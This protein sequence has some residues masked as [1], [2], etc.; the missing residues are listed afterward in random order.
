MSFDIHAVRARFPALQK[1]VT[2]PDGSR[3]PPILLNCGATTPPMREV[4]ETVNAMAAHYG[5]LGRGGGPQQA[6]AEALRRDFCRRI[7]RFVGAPAD[8]AVIFGQ[9]TTHVLNPII[10]GL[11]LQSGDVAI[12]TDLGHNSTGLPL[13][14]YGNGA[15]VQ[16]IG[17]Y[18]K[19]FRLDMGQ[20]AEKVNSADARLKAVIVPHACNLTGDIQSIYE[21]ARWTHT[22]NPD[23]VFIVD[24]AQSLARLPIKMG[25]LEELTRIDVVAGCAHK[26]YGTPGV[27]FAVAPYMFASRARPLIVGGGTVDFV[28]PDEVRFRPTPE[29]LS[30]GTP[31]LIA[32]AALVRAMQELEAL[33]LRQGAILKHELALKEQFYFL[34]DKRPLPKPLKVFRQDDPDRL[35]NTTGTV[36]LTGAEREL[37]TKLAAWGLESRFGGS[38]APL[39]ALQLLGLTS[40]TQLASIKRMVVE[41]GREGCM[42]QIKLLRLSPAI[43]TS[44]E[45]IETAFTLLHWLAGGRPVSGGY[46]PDRAT[47]QTYDELGLRKPTNKQIVLTIVNEALEVP[48]GYLDHEFEFKLELLAQ[49]AGLTINKV[50]FQRYIKTKAPDDLFDQTRLRAVVILI[51][52]RDEG[53]IIFNDRSLKNLFGLIDLITAKLIRMT[54]PDSLTE[55]LISYLRLEG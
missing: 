9:N 22:A 4:M 3:R 36:L 8:S 6:M 42:N 21:I 24:A 35:K 33:G 10:Y 47:G 20:L 52:L 37:E 16:T 26:I 23:A 15:T 7:G 31:N 48:L 12:D 28:S 53:L 41:L 18:P 45:E 51:R 43:L 34:A 25:K 49:K 50:R 19:T 1:F 46:I 38:C 40:D 44:S 30:A 32:M 11:D 2:L 14:Q 27:A 54:T 5:A 13:R 17:V 39:I 55:N 29:R